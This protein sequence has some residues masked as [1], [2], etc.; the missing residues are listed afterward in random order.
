MN[1]RVFVGGLTYRVGERDIEKFFRKCG[2]IR[3]IAMKNGF[4]F[5]EF[6][7]YRDAEDAVYEMN[8]KDLLGERVSVERARGTPRGS[9]RGGGGRSYR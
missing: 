4:A 2:R 7:D 5:V 9:D 6:D 1:T 8:G 3:E